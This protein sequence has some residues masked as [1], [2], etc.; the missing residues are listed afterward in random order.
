MRRKHIA[1]LVLITA[2]A[3]AAYLLWPRASSDTTRPTHGAPA[4]SLT[5]QHGRYLFNV[6]LHTPEELAGLLT[7]AEQLAQSMR[8]DDAH[9][10][11]AMVL[12]G[13]EIEMFAK[14]NY[15][16]FRKTVDQAA[17]LDASHVIEIKMCLTEMRRLGLR[18]EDIPAFIELVPYGP[19]EEERLR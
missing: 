13:P 5:E 3:A 17:R 1:V 11:I 14:K 12:H 6:T 10:G 18:K 7:R 9:T 8:T 2:I 15:P 16:R 19:D 4:T